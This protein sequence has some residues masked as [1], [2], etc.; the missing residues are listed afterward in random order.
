[1]LSTH[2]NK[3]TVQFHQLTNNV[4]YS[5]R[6]LHL[7]ALTHQTYSRIPSDHVHMLTQYLWYVVVSLTSKGRLP[8]SPIS[9]A[10]IYMCSDSNIWYTHPWKVNERSS[11]NNQIRNTAE[12]SNRNSTL[13]CALPAKAS[14]HK[15]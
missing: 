1:M 5:L 4:S 9:A 7:T 6:E 11:A 13:L 10:M 8:S 3:G 2:P 14:V 12:P 15:S